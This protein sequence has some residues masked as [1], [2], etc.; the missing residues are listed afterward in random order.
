MELFVDAVQLTNCQITVSV[1]ELDSEQTFHTQFV[2][3]RTK[4]VFVLNIEK[5]QKKK[6]RS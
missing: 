2:P 3:G 6:G 4:N 1:P 5:V